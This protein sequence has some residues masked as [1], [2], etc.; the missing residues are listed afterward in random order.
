MPKDGLINK[1]NSVLAG[2]NRSEGT[3]PDN[4]K[5][6]YG[7]F[8]KNTAT[9]KYGRFNKDLVNT[10]RD[11]GFNPGGFAPNIKYIQLRG[12]QPYGS[13]QLP[14]LLTRTWADDYARQRAQNEAGQI[15]L[16]TT[17]RLEEIASNANNSLAQLGFAGGNTSAP[18]FSSFGQALGIL[19]QAKADRLGTALEGQFQS[20]QAI[21]QGEAATAGTLG[22]RRGAARPNYTHGGPFSRYPYGTARLI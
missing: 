19:R 10:Q 12:K 5:Y 17:K 9:A 22:V 11:A 18:Q 4:S 21:A 2:N 6:R 8:D 7:K 16:T 14:D 20:D 13:T 1:V 15:A 3:V